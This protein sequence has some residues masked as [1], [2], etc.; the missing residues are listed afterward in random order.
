MT[1]N[2][3]ARVARELRRR[4]GV[5]SRRVLRRGAGGPARAFAEA[6][7]V[8]RDAVLSRPDHVAWGVL[9]R[10]RVE[11][12]LRRDPERLDP[13]SRAQVLRLATVFV[14]T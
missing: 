5:E 13:R 11:R 10:G 4:L 1:Q 9:D 8:T 6:F 12:L 3:R 7:R 2:F 14:E